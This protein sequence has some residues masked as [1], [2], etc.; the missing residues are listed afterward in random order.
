MCSETRPNAKPETV[1]EHLNM[2]HKRKFIAVK[3]NVEGDFYVEEGCCTMCGVPQA[4]A[5][6]L[7]GG[8]DDK[9]N[10]THDQ[11]FVKK[12]PNNNEE[13]NKMI[14]TLATQELLCIR[15]CGS[16]LEIKK[17]IKEVGEEN[18]IDWI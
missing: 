10:A 16:D 1:I 11:C 17:R 15:Y 12:Q 13:L 18:Q 5:P 6:E 2:T 9:C 3:E 4:E 14:N 7:F 8:F